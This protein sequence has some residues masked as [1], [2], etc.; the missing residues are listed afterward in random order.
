MQKV[1]K[2]HIDFIKKSMI[3]SG[4]YAPADDKSIEQAALILTMLDQAKEELESYVQT[5]ATGATN[6]SPEM[7]N[8][9]GLISDFNR[10][11][12]QLGL[13]P[14]SRKKLDI[15]KKKEVK[16]SVLELRKKAI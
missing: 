10:I 4:I 7:A 11:A 13:T 8:V 12:A 9:R 1:N 2:K 3:E 15:Q 5:F 6:V 14:M 16:S